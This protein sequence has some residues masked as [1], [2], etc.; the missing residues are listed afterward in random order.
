MHMHSFKPSQVQRGVAIIEFAITLPLLL[1]LLLAIAEFGRM[2]Y[3]YNILL[4]AS[5]D[6]GRYVSGQA[7]NRTLGKIDLTSDLKAKAQTVAFFSVPSSLVVGSVVEV[8]QVEE[9]SEHIQV[10]ITRTFVPLIGNGIP[11]FIGDGVALNLPLVATTVM[12]VL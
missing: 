9:D 8:T 11:S 7:W 1:L 12:R 6:A 10:S 2:L 4:Q 3:Q 5:R